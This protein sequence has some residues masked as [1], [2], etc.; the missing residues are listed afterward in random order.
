MKVTKLE[1]KNI[2]II[3]DVA[4]ELNK[5]LLLFYGDIRQGKSTILNAVGWCFGGSF[6]QDI[7]RHGENEASVT[8]YFDGGYVTRQWYRGRDGTTKSRDIEMKVDGAVIQEPV[9]EIKK[10]L[11]PFLLDQDFLRS[12]SELE[13]K[14]FF[15]SL[16]G[17]ETKAL[18]EEFARAGAEAT[19]LRSKLKGYGDI[20]LTPVETVD[21][22]SL[23]TQL[24][25]IRAAHQEE[26][27][28]ITVSNQAAL[29]HN[30]QVKE[31]LASADGLRSHIADLK[32]QLSAAEAT[33]GSYEI[34]C[35]A[36]P[37]K[38][39]ANTPPLPNTTE[40]E[41]Q[42]SEAL[43]QEVKRGHYLSN[44]ARHEARKLDEARLGALE[45][46]RLNIRDAKIA[47]LKNASETCGVPGLAFYE[48]GSFCYQ[49]VEAGMLSTSQ[50]MQL[51]SDL[52]ALYPK[53]FGLDLI[54]RAESLGKS[55][56]EFVERAKTENKTILATIVGERPA[57]APPEVG[58]FVVEGG[59]LS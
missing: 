6:P 37:E 28:R 5:P 2:G 24:A 20:D 43:A 52:S 56:Y 11:N 50:I 35:T 48:D 1:I 45:A 30:Q 9:R 58:V 47:R 41:T 14:K 31:T 36:N 34:F 44:L 40:I 7:I 54:D 27:N 46:T 49:G 55:I 42:I 39:L 22:S 23:K 51:S 13:R 18:D 8:L 16:F 33:L 59:K 38:A 17:L 21:V 19:E 32:T 15:V 29:K 53:G 3:E 26:V 10:F 25:S 12:K 57:A 4:I